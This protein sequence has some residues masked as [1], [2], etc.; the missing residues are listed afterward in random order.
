MAGGAASAWLSAGGMFSRC[1][2][3]SPKQGADEAELATLLPSAEG[4]GAA[5]ATDAQA[6][7]LRK[8]LPAFKRHFWPF[9]KDSGRGRFLAASTLALCLL[10]A[11]LSVYISYTARDFNSALT[12]KDT[13]G[14]YSGIL[15][16]VGV[17]LFAIPLDATFGFVQSHLALCWRVWLTERLLGQ[18]FSHNAFYRLS[19]PSLQAGGE[20]AASGAVLDNPD[21]RICQDVAGFTASSI[22]LTVTL[23]EKSLNLVGFS[24]VL[25]SISPKLTVF[26]FLYAFS[27][28]YFTVHIFGSP[29]ITSNA[30]ILRQ[31]ADLR[32]ALLRVR[33]HAEAIAF[34][35]AGG[36]ERQVVQ[37]RLGT[38]LS[39]RTLLIWWQRNM[40]GFQLCY[41]CASPTHAAIPSAVTP[42]FS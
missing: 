15:K 10:S 36:S 12:E 20:D 4:G 22:V 19:R 14:F 17:I 9:L 30:A 41:T 26:L 28:S 11:A 3:K 35:R 31:E 5:G 23:L 29:I 25:W 40:T 6:A 37:S 39:S 2:R 24:S 1:W 21:Q 34:Y 7:S 27:G 18:Y 42:S 32:Y 38:L 13:D 16:F 8:L 33:E